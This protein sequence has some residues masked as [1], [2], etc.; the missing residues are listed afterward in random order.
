MGTRLGQ[1]TR[2]AFKAAASQTSP[3]VWST[4]WVVLLCSDRIKERQFEDLT[5]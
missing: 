4:W 3:S 2:G 5:R 1:G